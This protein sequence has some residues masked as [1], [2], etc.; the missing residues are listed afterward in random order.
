MGHTIEA[1][2]NCKL[3][4]VDMTKGCQEAKNL[5]KLIQFDSCVRPQMSLAGKWKMLSLLPLAEEPLSALWGDAGGRG[6]TFHTQA[7][8]FSYTQMKRF[9]CCFYN[10]VAGR[11]LLCL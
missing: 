9:N 7:I 4:T 10:F 6:M 5:C 8:K 1:F 2:A 11:A 3:K